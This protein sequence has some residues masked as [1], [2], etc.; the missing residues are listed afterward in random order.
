[1]TNSFQS[2]SSGSSVHVLVRIGTCFCCG[3]S[4]HMGERYHVDARG[5]IRC[6]DH[7]PSIPTQF[8][9]IVAALHT[10]SHPIW[11]DPETVRDALVDAD[12]LRA[13]I[14]G[15]KPFFVGSTGKTTARFHK[16]VAFLQDPTSRDLWIEAFGSELEGFRAL[17]NAL[18]DGTH[19]K[20]C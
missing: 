20:R 19:A 9:E 16:R 5:R 2:V 15:A 17:A 6:A 18:A 12:V 13:E 11:S 4:I 3:S 7:A 10:A 14:S 8:W 1:M